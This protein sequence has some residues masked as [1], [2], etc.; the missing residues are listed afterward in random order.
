[1]VIPSVKIKRCGRRLAEFQFSGPA[2]TADTL[3]QKNG[4]TKSHG[5]SFGISWSKH[6]L[7]WNQLLHSR[8][9]PPSAGSLAWHV[10]NFDVPH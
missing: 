6:H 1:M 5:S 4:E 8:Q 7:S 3:E 10:D 2:F 9:K